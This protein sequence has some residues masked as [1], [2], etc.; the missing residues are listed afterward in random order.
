MDQGLFLQ[1]NVLRKNTFYEASMFLRNLLL[2]LT[3]LSGT[4]VINEFLLN[5]NMPPIKSS[6]G[7]TYTTTV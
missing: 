5:P 1:S 2:T 7:I 3:K 6:S 4:R